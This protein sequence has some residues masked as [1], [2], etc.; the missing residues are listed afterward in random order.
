MRK[1][2]SLLLAALLLGGLLAGCGASAQK[3]DVPAADIAESVMGALGMTDKMVDTASVVIEGY[4]Q[5]SPDQFGDYAVYHN[6]YGTAVDEFGIF[7]A[8]TLS[9]SEVKEA[10]EGYLVKLRGGSMAALYTP[11]E[12]PKLD[13]AELR[14][15]GDYVMYCV[16]SDADRVTAFSAFDAALK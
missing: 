8:G 15:N 4:M 7:K 1:T 2:I 10:V 14:T 6:A 9:V 13:G 12:M 16:L 3:K 11:E 5:L